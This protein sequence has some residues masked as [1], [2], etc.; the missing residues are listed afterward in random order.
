MALQQVRRVKWGKT[1]DTPHSFIVRD[2]ESRTTNV[3][4]GNSADTSTTRGL[5]LKDELSVF[6]DEMPSYWTIFDTLTAS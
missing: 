2:S 1:C 3:Y 6:L 4:F 5:S